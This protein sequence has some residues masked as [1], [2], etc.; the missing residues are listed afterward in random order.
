MSQANVRNKFILFFAY[1][2]YPW[3]LAPK[4]SAKEFFHRTQHMRITS[5]LASV[6][7][8]KF[9][10]FYSCQPMDNALLQ[11]LDIN[12]INMYVVYCIN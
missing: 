10:G 6:L 5:S 9:F 2:L 7:V 11:F 1:L 4:G 8:V 12:R 3:N